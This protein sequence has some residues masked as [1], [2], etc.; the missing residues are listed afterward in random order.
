MKVLFIYPQYPNTFWSFKYALK[1]ISKKASLPP[2]GLLTVAAMLPDTWEKKLVDMNVETLSD[3]D[4]KWAD[5]VFISA[6]SIQKKSA[7]E[8]IKKCNDLGV[9]VVAGGP[10]FTSGPE[11]YDHVDHLVLNEAEITLP[12]F[13]ADLEKGEL[14]HSYTSGE[15]GDMTG[16]PI[17]DWNLVKMERYA[18]A[19]IQYSRGC[20]FA[21]DFCNITVLY[22]RK[23][24]TKDT[25]QIIAELDSLYDHGWREGVFFVD[26]NF[27]GNRGKLKRETLPAM[28]DWMERKGYPFSLNTEASIDLAD[29][30]EL[31]E[32]MTRAGF[33]TVFIGIETPHEESLA[34]CSKTQN[35][36]RDMMSCIK[37]MQHAGLEVQAG[38]IVGFDSDPANIFDKVITFI[39]ESGIA[40]AMVGLLNAPRGTKLFQRLSNEGRLLNDATGDNTDYSINFIPKMNKDALITGY[41]RIVDTIYS[42]KHY[43]ARVKSFLKEYHRPAN[44]KSATHFDLT[45]FKALLRS[46][47]YLGVLGKERFQYWKLFFWSLFTRPRLFPLAITLTIYGFHFRK[48]FQRA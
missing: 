23:P 45:G 13:L 11:E 16:I 25:A 4:I 48:T 27:I 10:H 15:W 33:D 43:Y 30:A 1:F 20:P 39:Q 7:D 3:A 8:V 29:D 21:C 42:P 47:V 35:K 19:N 14:K 41:Q 34:E 17:P 12:E 9:K 6:M 5:F 24:R 22:G 31:M 26:D 18:S 2:L 40:T 32:L 44:N 37:K 46:M 28:I 36:T 38:F